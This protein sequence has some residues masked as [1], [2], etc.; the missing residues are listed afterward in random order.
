MYYPDPDAS[1]IMIYAQRFSGPSNVQKDGNVDPPAPSELTL[2][3]LRDEINAF[4]LVSIVV[5][6]CF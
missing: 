4:P 6:K 2:S 1:N 5:S 3:E